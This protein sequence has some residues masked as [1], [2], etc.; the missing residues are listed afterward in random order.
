MN[1]F[2]TAICT[3]KRIHSL[4]ESIQYF[5]LRPSQFHVKMP[6]P[7]RPLDNTVLA[8][9]TVCV[10]ISVRALHFKKMPWMS[11]VLTVRCSYYYRKTSSPNF[12]RAFMLA[13][14]SPKLYRVRYWQWRCEAYISL[15]PPVQALSHFIPAVSSTG[16]G[17]AAIADQYRSVLRPN[18]SITICRCSLYPS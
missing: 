3:A 7:A 13:F 12:D 9:L 11:A 16:I 8:P 15:P 2:A 10:D 18:L 17:V 4:S 6:W 1:K 5:V 14:L